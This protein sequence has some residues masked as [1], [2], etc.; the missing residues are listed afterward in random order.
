MT[1]LQALPAF[2]DN[3]IWCY[4]GNNGDSIV[5]DPGDAQPVLEAMANGLRIAALFITHHHNDHIGGLDALRKLCKG[6]V[7][8]PA[9]ER[10]CGIDHY[11]GGGD[12]IM[13]DGFQD[14]RVLSV[15][16]HTRSH[17]AYTDDHVVFCGDTL[18][19]LGCG[20]L[21][22]GSAEQL[23]DSLDRLADLPDS[24][25]VCCTHEYTLS[26][27]RFAEAVEPINPRRAKYVSDI[28]AQLAQGKP[29]LPSQIK[30]EKDCN[31]FL[32]TA[33]PAQLSGLAQHLGFM[34]ETRVARLQAMRMWKDQF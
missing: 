20:R 7:Y 28:T 5:V 13:L 23:L 10:I 4:R 2:T 11:V 8:G 15:P 22:E 31:P 29:S 12:S 6:N 27:A 21:F 1:T 16:G 30:I 24:T 26:N 14:F 32:R 33:F 9:D 34:P 18:F 17:I 19:S 25:L 3:Y